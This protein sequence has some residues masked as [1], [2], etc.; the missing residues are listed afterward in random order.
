MFSRCFGC[1]QGRRYSHLV[2]SLSGCVTTHATGR[3]YFQSMPKSVRAGFTLIE[4]LIVITIIGIMAALALPRLRAAS[5]DADAGMRT[6][7]SALQQAQRIAIVRQ[8]DVMVSFDTAGKRLRIVYDVNDNHQLDAGE[9][10]HWKSLEPGDRFVTP[11]SGVQLSGA[12]AIVGN[13]L[14]TRNSYPTVY[15]HRDGALSSEIE[16]YMSSYRPDLS[17]IRA[18]HVRQA[19]GRVQEYR[20]NGSTWI[21]VGL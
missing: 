12:A 17:D 20:Y 19:T 9:E 3:P 6:V 4:M 2:T 7:Q 15:Y 11:P 13:A 1:H 8:T 21:G 14:A 10:V 18:L 16:L 5:Y